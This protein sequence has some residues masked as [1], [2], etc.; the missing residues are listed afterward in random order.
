MSA[1]SGSSYVDHRAASRNR[2]RR[3]PRSAVV[4]PIALRWRSDQRLRRLIA[5]KNGIRL[6]ELGTNIRAL[7]PEGYLQSADYRHG[8]PI[9]DTDA[10]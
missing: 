9:N 2:R 6:V 3:L 8:D 10:T 4:I 5:P 1:A 7:G